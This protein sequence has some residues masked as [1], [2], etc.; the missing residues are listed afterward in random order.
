MAWNT[1]TRTALAFG[2][3]AAVCFLAV[4][5]MA[6]EDARRQTLG[7]AGR[8]AAHL[9]Q[10]LTH[11]LDKGLYER[12]REVR[13][14][15]QLEAAT[16]DEGR[17]RQVL[18]H[19]QASLQDYVWLGI[20]DAS[21]SVQ[22]ATDGL[23]EGQNV[24]QRP[25]YRQALQ[26]PTIGD[27]HPAVL[28]A[29]L[30]P[31]RG[32]QEPLRLL[33]VAAPLYRD[34][35]LVG[36][37]G[38]HLDWRWAEE[39]VRQAL[40]G[41]PAVPDLQ[42]L[43]VSREGQKLLG[44][45]EAAIE[46]WG[47]QRLHRL[48][49][50]GPAVLDW[51][52]GQAY[53]TAAQASSGYRDFPGLGWTVLVRQPARTALQAAHDLQMRIWMIGLGAA[54]LFAVAGWWL[55][56][57]LAAP[58]RTIAARARA[59]SQRALPDPPTPAG[60]DELATLSHALADL[61][62]QLRERERELLELNASLEQR[63]RERT[64]ALQRLNAD[65]ASFS[66]SVAHDL[67]GPIGAM[68]AAAQLIEQECGAQLS[69]THRQLL[70]L[71]GEDGHR[72][73]RLTD[74]LLVLSRVDQQA[75]TPAMVDME[76]LVRQVLAELQARPGTQLP[77][78]QLEALPMAWGDAAL[79]RQVWVNLLANAI[80]FTGPVPN[81]RIAIGA[82]VSDETVTY[83]VRDN[84]VGF[85]MQRYG[86]LFDP[87]Q[88]LHTE[89]EFAGSGVGLSIVRRVVQRHG[90]QVWAQSSPGQGA[91]FYFSLRSGPPPQAP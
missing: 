50:E 45:P 40:R 37:L 6:A 83:H 54:A 33:D 22:A 17:W 66:R 35:R 27:V 26:G 15:A 64:E 70:H 81:P 80:K 43:I 57:R 89:A 79:L 71:I 25:W 55:A 23:L 34:G 78:I 53:L 82:S 65:M 29:S 86:A 5:W 13:N 74:Q 48:A 85:D 38:A 51:P 18:Q 91:C 68:A 32:G 56:G 49:T 59:L 61:V 62:A 36:V 9:A 16:A 76:P 8:H 28:L 12:M 72:L 10:H 11:S 69:A 63:V 31:G 88:R 3:L 90:G 87:F 52:D 47:V 58:L 73:V 30:L 7:D 42:V 60:G 44:P 41:N 1:Q 14:V 46:A 67:K 21:G 4:G 77:D 24:S 39:E 2:V 19:M 75:W 84:G 20:T